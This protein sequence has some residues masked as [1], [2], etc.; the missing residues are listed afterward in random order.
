MFNVTVVPKL[1]GLYDATR[2]RIRYLSGT[3]DEDSEPTEDMVRS[4]Y[5]SSL[6]RVK[7]LST[8]EY[9]HLT[10][11]NVREWVVF[12][13]IFF[14]TTIVPMQMWL[15]SRSSALKMCKRKGH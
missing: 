8:A 15:S 4:G 11:Y 12:G 5:S 14:V 1:F 7:I 13:I 3:V 9:Q 2:A 10:S 6:G